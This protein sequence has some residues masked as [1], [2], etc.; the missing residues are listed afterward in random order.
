[1]SPH[2]AAHQS[3][4]IYRSVSWAS[5][6]FFQSES[7]GIR[8]ALHLQCTCKSYCAAGGQKDTCCLASKLAYWQIVK[9]NVHQQSV[10]APS[11]FLEIAGQGPKCGG[12]QRGCHRCFQLDIKLLSN[13][14]FKFSLLCRWWRRHD[15]P[16]RHWGGRRGSLESKPWVQLPCSQLWQ[17]CLLPVAQVGYRDYYCWNKTWFSQ[18]NSWQCPGVTSWLLPPCGSQVCPRYFSQILTKISSSPPVHTKKG[19][20]KHSFN[21]GQR[22]CSDIG[23]GCRCLEKHQQEEETSL[24]QCQR[25]LEHCIEDGTMIVVIYCVRMQQCTALMWCHVLW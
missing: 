22:T 10:L 9:V 2:P 18:W 20:F 12:W 24:T 17:Q 6:L 5:L 14:S 13:F 4:S 1:M 3:F 16:E 23:D 11:E 25:R 8:L 15:L 21:S 19:V 7:P